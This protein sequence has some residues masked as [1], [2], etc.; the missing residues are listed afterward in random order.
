MSR[1]QEFYTGCIIILLSDVHNFLKYTY[2][3]KVQQK[4]TYDTFVWFSKY[5]RKNNSKGFRSGGCGGQGTGPSSSM[6][7]ILHLL[8]KGKCGGAPPLK[9]LLQKE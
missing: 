6:Q 3:I 8:N 4:T 9:A 1:T 5:A 2:L 7:C